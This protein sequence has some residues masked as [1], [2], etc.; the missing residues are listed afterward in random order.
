MW[1]RLATC[2]RL[3][4]GLFTV[5]LW[6][7][8]AL[9]LD[10]SHESNVFPETR[11][12]RIFLPPSYEKSALRY[13][14]IYWFHGYGERSNLGP[15][16]KAYDRG[17]DYN[18]D[19]L[20]NFVA[21][22]DVIIVKWD[23]ENAPSSRPY[24]IGPVETDRQF[25][26]YFPELV[27]HID[28]TYRTIPDREHRATAGLSMGGFMSFWIAGKYPDLVSSASS[29]MGSP[30]F[31]V[32]PRAFPVE[33]SHDVMSAN[34]AGVRTRLITG[35]QDFIQ[36]YHRQ[37]NLF[38]RIPAHETENFDSD[39]GVPALA[40]TLEF[41]MNAFANPLPRP[42]SWSHVDIY[43]NFKVWDWTV[44]SDRRQPGFTSIHGAS[45]TGF[46]SSVQEWIPGGKLLPD[47]HLTITT[48]PIY[49]KN[50]RIQVI[51]RTQSS[52][53]RQHLKTD[54]SGRLHI[55]L[56][57]G[58]SL[59]VIG[60]TPRNQRFPDLGFETAALQPL[61]T[62]FQI[63]D[64]R[65]FDVFQHA[66]EKQ[67]LTLGEGNADGQ[68][69]PGEQ[70][71]ILFPDSGA[72]RAAELFSSDACLDLTTRIS[73]NWATYDH[74]GASAKYTLAK[75]SKTCPANHVMTLRARVLFPNKPNHQPREF[76]I[77]LP[78]TH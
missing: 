45:R 6:S 51:T 74:V 16:S 64:H 9:I 26:L 31:V 58:F 42:E 46:V 62:D 30:E 21:T 54:P 72:Y 70:I 48:G 55:A 67:P 38:W 36:F 5:P 18:G 57:G 71:A 13:P 39:H 35:S 34:Y 10:R 7:A 4:I 24:N 41:H 25:P 3:A 77:E 69:D 59:I 33:Y 22:H 8:D 60:K 37:M 68:A 52:N 61:T 23:G 47:V 2:G 63:A 73:D 75:I 20:A 40:K 78:I 66:V 44:E 28:A 12:Y 19:N 53:R 14:V 56:N 76:T 32:G 43:P 15:P 1:C 11:R 17:T 27:A 29:F 50:A 65:T 49:R